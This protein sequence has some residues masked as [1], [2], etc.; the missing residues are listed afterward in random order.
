MIPLI[1]RKL[2]AKTIVTRSERTLI[3][4]FEPFSLLPLSIFYLAI[5]KM[6]LAFAILPPLFPLPYV[7]LS[8]R[9]LKSAKPA[10]LIILKRTVVTSTVDIHKTPFTMHLV[11]LPFALIFSALVPN[12]LP[13]NYKINTIS[14]N[15]VIRKISFVVASIHKFQ[16]SFSRFGSPI[17][18]SLK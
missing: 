15:L 4:P 12:V 16:N 9:P 6:K 13:Y 11:M 2:S 5:C 18:L 8:I 14:V 17:K 10:L 1:C 3:S 7:L